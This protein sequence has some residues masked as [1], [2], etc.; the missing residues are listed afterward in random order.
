MERPDDCGEAKRL[1]AMTDSGEGVDAVYHSGSD[2]VPQSVVT[3]P[4]RRALAT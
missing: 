1:K 4:Q 2:E 3:V